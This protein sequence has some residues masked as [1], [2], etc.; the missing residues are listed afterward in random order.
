MEFSKFSKFVSLLLLV[1]QSDA[2]DG[3]EGNT[4]DGDDCNSDDL[5]VCSSSLSTLR[6]SSLDVGFLASCSPP[7]SS[8]SSL[9]N[10]EPQH[11]SLPG[12]F[13]ENPIV[14]VEEALVKETPYH[15]QLTDMSVDG[16]P[17]PCPASLESQSR[18]ESASPLKAH[19]DWRTIRWPV[20]PPITPQSGECL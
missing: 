7:T 19:S 16:V 3:D 18:L 5:E 6:L 11:T 15:S 9:C 8:H 2:S 1:K 20:L 4:D 17:S 13:K 10:Q 14:Q 12:T